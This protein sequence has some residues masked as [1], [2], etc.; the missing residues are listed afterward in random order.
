MGRAPKDGVKLPTEDINLAVLRR[1]IAAAVTEAQ[2]GRE[3][4]C[5]RAKSAR[6]LMKTT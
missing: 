3:R 4:A 2:S 1:A 6:L 5:Q